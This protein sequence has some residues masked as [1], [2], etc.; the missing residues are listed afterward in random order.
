[1]CCTASVAA[2]RSPSW[3][4]GR[5]GCGGRAGRRGRGP[6][7]AHHTA[8]EKQ[9]EGGENRY[10][11]TAS[12]ETHSGVVRGRGAPPGEQRAPAGDQSCRVWSGAAAGTGIRRRQANRNAAPS[13]TTTAPPTP[14]PMYPT[15]LAV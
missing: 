14:A 8:D 12:H 7:P 13:I 4:C 10:D 11:E 5:G 3:V 2:V 15:V 1:M 6:V 9:H